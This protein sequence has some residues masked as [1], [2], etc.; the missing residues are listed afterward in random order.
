MSIVQETSKDMNGV[1]NVKDRMI[2]SGGWKTPSFQDVF[3]AI[4]RR[5]FNCFYRVKFRLKPPEILDDFARDST[6]AVVT[7][8]SRQAAVAARHCLA[9]ARGA[10]RWVNLSDLPTPP[11]ADAPS[12]G[13]SCRGCVRPVTLSISDTQKKIR[14]FV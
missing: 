2:G 11:L 4:H 6:Y 5:L 8:T 7:F 9:D 1:E 12:C 10:D 14:H 13:T 3:K